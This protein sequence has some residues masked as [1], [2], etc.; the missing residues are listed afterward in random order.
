MKPGVGFRLLLRLFST[1]VMHGASFGR[2]H[3][4]A[5]SA[6][7]SRFP[8]QKWRPH[9]QRYSFK[10]LSVNV[11]FH[12]DYTIATHPETA[13]NIFRMVKALAVHGAAKGLLTDVHAHAEY[14]SNGDL[15]VYDNQ[16]EADEDL[17]AAKGTRLHNHWSFMGFTPPVAHLGKQNRT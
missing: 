16:W 10:T 7:D 12:D 5:R 2:N 15:V 6:H 17:D 11:S 14:E 8:G 13:H 3:D 9:P 4:E 1:L